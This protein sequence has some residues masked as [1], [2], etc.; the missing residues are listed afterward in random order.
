MHKI[1]FNDNPLFS[2]KIFKGPIHQQVRAAL[3]YLKNSVIKEFVRKVPDRAEAQ[4]RR[5]RMR[6]HPLQMERWRMDGKPEA[7]ELA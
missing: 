2:E 3:G 6:H 4:K 7:Q 1:P 5:S